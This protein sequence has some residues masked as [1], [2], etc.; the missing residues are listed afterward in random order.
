MNR[1]EYRVTSPVLVRDIGPFRQRNE[2]VVL[3]GHHHLDD[4]T[5]SEDPG[6][7][8]TRVQR[9]NLLRKLLTGNTAAILSTVTRVKHYNAGAGDRT[10]GYQDRAYCGDHRLEEKTVLHKALVGPFAFLQKGRF[11]LPAEATSK[12][13]VPCL[14]HIEILITEKNPGV[15]FILQAVAAC[16]VQRDLKVEQRP[17]KSIPFGTLAHVELFPQ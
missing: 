9:K 8:L 7:P 4:A 13:Q 6:E 12:G 17:V 16:D 1:N 14:H 10:H 15:V 11:L 5:R 3:T 2:P